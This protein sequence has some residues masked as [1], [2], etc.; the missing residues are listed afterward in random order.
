MVLIV[1]VDSAVTVLTFIVWLAFKRSSPIL[2][3]LQSQED[4]QVGGSV[5]AMKKARP[6]TVSTI[7]H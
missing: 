1:R 7:S 2:S 3:R 4:Y 5:L 6:V